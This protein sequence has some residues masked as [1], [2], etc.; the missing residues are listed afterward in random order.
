MVRNL[1]NSMRPT[2][3]SEVIGQQHLVGEGR[4]IW[5]MVEA[6]SLSSIILYG[7]PGVGKTSIA[8]AI[9]GSTGIEFKHYNA[10]VHGK[11]ELQA[12]ATQVKKTG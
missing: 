11:K 10:S 9:S 2:Q 12:Y 1:A 6:K 5:R 8:R 3:L 4:I 7:P